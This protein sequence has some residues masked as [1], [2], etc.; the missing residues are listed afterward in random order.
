MTST[1]RRFSEPSR[2]SD[3]LRVTVQSRRAF[4]AGVGIGADVEPEFVA[5]TTFHGRERGLHRQALHS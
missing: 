3:V 5:I 1:L 2:L 4:H